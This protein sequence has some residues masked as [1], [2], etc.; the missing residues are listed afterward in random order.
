MS[1]SK[2]EQIIGKISMSMPRIGLKMTV[3]NDSRPQ[4]TPRAAQSV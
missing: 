3:S 2:Y 4:N 1:V